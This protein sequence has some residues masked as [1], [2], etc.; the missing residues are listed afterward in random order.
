MRHPFRLVREIGIGAFLSF[1]FI[2]G[3][4]IIFILNP[5]FWALTTLW[6]LTEAGIIEQL[7]PGVI[8][9]I[10]S[11]QLFIGNFIFTYL[12]VAGALQRGLFDLTKYAR[13]HARSTGA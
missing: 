1:Q 7:F 10:A 6:L 5:I 4:T 3:G 12:T 9:Y 13:L 2:V 11:A 8:F